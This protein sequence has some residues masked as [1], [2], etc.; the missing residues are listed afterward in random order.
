MLIGFVGSHLNSKKMENGSKRVA[1]RMATHFYQKNEMGE[2]N[3]QT[4]WHDVVAW[5]KVADFAERNLV[6]GSRIM[7]D[8]SITYRTYP[9]KTGHLRYVTLITADSVMNL[10]R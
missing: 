10:D 2:K 8:G 1:I 3:Y 6:K 9:D 5:D 7:V 4:V